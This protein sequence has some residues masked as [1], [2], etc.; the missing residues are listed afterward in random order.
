MVRDPESQRCLYYIFF[1]FME[2]LEGEGKRVVRTEGLP[3]LPP[4][5]SSKY[6]TLSPQKAI[7]DTRFYPFLFFCSLDLT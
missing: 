6:I 2:K 1:S 3:I 4:I 7:G 5:L